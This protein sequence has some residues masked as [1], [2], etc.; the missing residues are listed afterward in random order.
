[1]PESPGRGSLVRQIIQNLLHYPAAA[2]ALKRLDELERIDKPGIT[3]LVQ[4]ANELQ[5]QPDLTPAAL[6]ERWRQRPDFHYIDKLLL[7]NPPAANLD[8]AIDEV[9]KA[10]DRLIADQFP[11]ERLDELM[12]RFHLGALSADEKQEL[13]NLIKMRGGG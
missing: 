7:R 10:T 3:L 4:L 8:I 5:E 11:Q 13:R 1:M 6:L 12:R 9:I 2:P